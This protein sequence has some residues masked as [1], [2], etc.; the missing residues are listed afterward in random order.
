MRY[1]GKHLILLVFVFYVHADVCAQTEIPRDTTYTV[2]GTYNKLKKQ[3]P[4]IQLVM[5]YENPG[6]V[7]Q[8]D[9]VYTI[10]QRGD[11]HRALKADIFYPKKIKRKLP[12]VILVHGGGWRSG[13]K[14]MNTPLA[15]H[16]TLEGYVVMSVEYQLSLEA[17]YPAA[18]HNL[19]AA[20]RWLRSKANEYSLDESKIAIIGG[21]AGGQ[22]ASL[23]GT[24]N[25]N[26]N[27][28]GDDGYATFSS[29]VQA[30][31]DLDG[32]LDFTHE[33]NLAVKR[34]DYSADVFWLGGFYEAAPEVWKEASP[35]THVSASTPPF[36]FIN[37]SQTR[38]H[39]GCNEMVEKL[40][41][42]GIKAEVVKLEDAPHSY[43]FFVPW[44]TPMTEHIV[45]FLNQ[46][47][48]K[49]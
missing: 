22:L 28:E 42:F 6:I 18:V 49:K 29:E 7:Q 48:K 40:H 39:A 38:F 16:L 20:I 27:F 33:E 44:F 43:W 2:L 9:V 21:S 13:D 14:S 47:L 17:K 36:L 45:T 24:T 1:F 11:N 8:N 10:L 15:R 41:A 5:P 30:V 26:R 25:G 4:T 12:G 35:I 23:I 37:S 32:L 31:V 34:T 3:Y 19:K 46:T